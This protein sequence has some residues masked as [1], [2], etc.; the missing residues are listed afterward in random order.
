MDHAEQRVPI[1]VARGL[2]KHFGRVTALAGSDLELYPG[3]V[4]GIIGDNGAGKSSLVKCLSGAMFADEGV[5]E[6]EGRPVHFRR[7]LDSRTA[8]IETV[9]Q[10]VA[11]GSAVGPASTMFLGR[12]RRRS[13]LLGSWLRVFDK[14]GTRRDSRL[15]IQALGIGTIPGSAEE[16]VETLSGRPRQTPAVARAALFASKVVMLDEPTAAL[17]VKES[18]LVLQLVRDLRARG[19]SVILVSHNLAHVFEVADRVHIQRLGRR[20][21]VVTPQ[22]HTRPEAV[23]IMNGAATVE[24]AV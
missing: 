17:D 10:T 22:S 2:V 5:I 14:S 21:A 24:N 9:Y 1:L 3:E 13:G 11:V 8:G 16:G 19:V 4:L 18:G 6:F 15:T 23:A 12:E 20:V 7:P